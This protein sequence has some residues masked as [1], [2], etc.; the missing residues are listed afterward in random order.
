M[1]DDLLTGA[2]EIGA[3]IDRTP[4]QANYLCVTGAIPAWK[5]AGRWQSRKSTLTKFYAELEAAALA[6]AKAKCSPEAAR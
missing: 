6:K 1:N 2:E 3:F 5:I 4:S